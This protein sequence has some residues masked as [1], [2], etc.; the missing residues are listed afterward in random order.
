MLTN[1]RKKS[2]NP[3]VRIMLALMALSF[4]GWAAHDVFKSS[5]SQDVVVFDR[6]NNITLNHF[7]K[8]K[9]EEINM[10]QKQQ[11]SILSEAEIKQLDI[12]NSVLSKLINDSIIN[13]LISYYS[14]DISDNLVLSFIKRI[15][16][17]QNEQGKFDSNIFHKIL[18]NSHQNQEEYLMHVKNALLQDAFKDI[19]LNTFK[20]P[21]IMTENIVNYMAESRDFNLFMIDLNKKVV[22]LA[23]QEPSEEQLKNFY[24][25]NKALFTVPETRNITYIN[26][27]RVFIR[28]KVHIKDDELLAFYYENQDDYSA[29]FEKVKKQ[30]IDDF[31][32]QKTDELQM[33]LA[34]NLED[35]IDSGANMQEIADKYNLQLQN[36]DNVTYDAIV[37]NKLAL[38]EAADNIFN[39]IESE[40]SYPL[41]I[42]QDNF[43][44]LIVELR[45]I[46]PANVQNFS[47]VI[48][49]VKELWYVEQSRNANI[50]AITQFAQQYA[51][52]NMA[53]NKLIDTHKN[54]KL[55]RSDLNSE[56]YVNGSVSSNN[57][58]SAAGATK[59]MLPQE[60]KF[61]I[62]FTPVGQNTQ[63]VTMEN[64]AYFAH[65]N[66]R[67][68]NQDKVKEINDQYAQNID[69]T[70]KHSIFEEL[71]D[72]FMKK[73]RTKINKTNIQTD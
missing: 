7:L 72:Y 37:N 69:G 35:D 14:L 67:N 29:D 26:I 16:I 65:I 51:S 73:E 24:D 60:L 45:S 61:A 36:M 40:I 19:F 62:F 5:Y 71:I 63:I 33:E 8:V 12:N 15:P 43:A 39:M 50:Q 4:I 6:A 34:Q 27:P 32:Q 42:N 68:T 49:K 28:N 3:F 9:S 58:K 18:N 59:I 56:N 54:L 10:I 31:K 70:I 44:L 2:H 46:T 21:Q 57:K 48:N 25:N 23:L 47:K 20:V 38:Y 30:V 64:H 52:N 1:I 66:S 41:Q 17:F 11:G 53:N 55:I 13:Y 22:D